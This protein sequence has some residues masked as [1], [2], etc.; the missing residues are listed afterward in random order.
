MPRVFCVWAMR[1]CR[2]LGWAAGCLPQECV[3]AKVQRQVSLRVEPD[4]VVRLSVRPARPAGCFSGARQHRPSP[5]E[6]MNSSSDPLGKSTGGSQPISA[7]HGARQSVGSP[8]TPP[9]P[10][11]Q[12]T[13]RRSTS[14]GSIARRRVDYDAD[15]DD[16]D[17]DDPGRQAARSGRYVDLSFFV[18]RG[19]SGLGWIGSRRAVEL[20]LRAGRSV[21]DADAR[22]GAIFA[23]WPSFW[24]WRRP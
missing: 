13:A 6:F 14:S 23:F 3:A 16:D 17:Q 2:A 11:R 1:T 18:A 21:R 10:A 5:R 9:A 8:S 7:S 15:V 4:A 20:L 12:A 22:R 19:V 24:P